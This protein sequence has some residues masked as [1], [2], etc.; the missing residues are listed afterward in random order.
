MKKTIISNSPKQTK[1]VAE[2]FIKEVLKKR[3]KIKNALVFILEGE[4]GA[5]KTEFLKG[6]AKAL[7]IKEKINSPTFVIMKRFPLKRKDFNYLWHLDLY[8]LKKIKELLSLALNDLLKDKKNLIFIEWGN[9]IKKVLPKNHGEIKIK[10][11]ANNKR[12][13]EINY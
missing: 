12:L 6:V 10:I 2:S 4:L 3:P 7:K 11:L 5:G 8:R 13:I 9:K 1:K